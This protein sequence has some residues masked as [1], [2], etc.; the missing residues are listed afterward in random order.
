MTLIVWRWSFDNGSRWSYKLI[1]QKISNSKEG[2]SNA[3]LH[4]LFPKRY[5]PERSRSNLWN[6]SKSLWGRKVN[7]GSRTECVDELTVNC[8]KF[9]RDTTKRVHMW[10]GCHRL[11]QQTPARPILIRSDTLR[12]RT[13]SKKF[14][15]CF[16]D[17]N[18]A[19]LW[20][21]VMWEWNNSSGL[22]IRPSRDQLNRMK[23]RKECNASSKF[24]HD[25]F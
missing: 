4:S 15:C 9:K 24:C 12:V 13:K 3:N 25:I 22:N 16:C 5:G 21:F 8:I 2:K 1:V 20:V 17:A 10:T 14:G 18:V 11:I 6:A 7:F 23:V 19:D